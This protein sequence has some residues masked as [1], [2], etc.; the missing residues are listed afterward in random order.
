M[1]QSE[2]QH[3][4]QL[5]SPDRARDQKILKIQKITQAF[6]LCMSKYY[7]TE[8]YYACCSKEQ[9]SKEKMLV[10]LICGSLMRKEISLNLSRFKNLLG[11]GERRGRGGRSV[12][13]K[14]DFN[15]KYFQNTC[16]FCI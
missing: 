6:T 9:C 14:V 10:W 7:S 8:F 3:V 16:L 2:N 13:F 5:R 12:N 15:E 11:G 4:A 1:K